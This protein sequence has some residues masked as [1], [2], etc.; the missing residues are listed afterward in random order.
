V[1]ITATPD[2]PCCAVIFSSVAPDDREGYAEMA[3]AMD[4][5]AAEQDDCFG[6]EA[7]RGD[8]GLRITVSHWRDEA[9]IRDRREHARHRAAQKIGRERWYRGYSLRVAKV[10][11][12]TR[13]N[14]GVEH[15]G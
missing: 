9:A 15:D 3:A 6:H 7:A 8:S 10:E 1:T 13:A 14:R 12:V 2:P 4:A 11:R 5:L